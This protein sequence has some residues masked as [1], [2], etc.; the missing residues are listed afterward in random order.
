M[1]KKTKISLIKNVLFY[2]IPYLF[3]F[4]LK[5]IYKSSLPLCHVDK[6]MLGIVGGFRY[7]NYQSIHMMKYCF[8]PPFKLKL[9]SLFPLIFP[10]S[11]IRLAP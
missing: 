3:F 2:F 5:Y 10:I 11:M 6:G 1:D 9:S 4:I 8:N 7:H